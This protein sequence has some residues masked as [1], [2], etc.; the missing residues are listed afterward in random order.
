[1]A[2]ANENVDALKIEKEILDIISKIQKVKSKK[3]R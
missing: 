3:K 2:V 1:M